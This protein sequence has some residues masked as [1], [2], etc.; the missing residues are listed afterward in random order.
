MNYVGIYDRLINSRK[1]LLREKENDG[2][3]ESHHIKPK[4]LA[5]NNN[6]SNLVL[7]T[8]REHYLAHWLLYKFH[9]GK[10]KARMAY[11]FFMMCR[12][13]PNQ[14]RFL[15]SRQYQRAKENMTKSCSGT[16]HPRYGKK[17]W[18]D[19][20]KKEIS[21]RMKGI[22]NHRYG[23]PSWNKGLTAET[24]EILREVGNKLKKRYENEPHPLCG[25]KRSQETKNKISKLHKGKKKSQEHKDKISKTLTGRKLP[26]EVVKKM[27]ETRKGISQQTI[28]CPHC[29]VCG[30]ISAM[31][32]W[33]FNNCKSK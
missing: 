30:G 23:K 14:T 19:E 33:H 27:S 5:G 6:K 16:N 1:I 13:N 2:L 29:Q 3:L 8:P 9:E 17:L 4:S 10:D 32:R 18:S 7:L 21:T 28:T 24:S 31:K 15:T 11:A 22:G 20:Q 26:P 12:R 25:C